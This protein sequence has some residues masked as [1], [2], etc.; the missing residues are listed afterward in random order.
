[1][2]IS[3]IDSPYAATIYVNRISG[4]D[5]SGNGTSGAP[6]KSF[7]KG[8]SMALS[9]D[10]LDLVGTF[11]WT[12]IDETGD[13][14]TSGYTISKNITIQ[15]RGIDET[16]IQAHSS[17]YSADRRVFTLGAFAINFKNLTIRHGYL[18]AASYNAGGAGI[19]MNNG[20]SNAVNFEKCRI[21]KNITTTS[22][23][24]SQW[25]GG[26]AILVYNTSATGGS[27]NFEQCIINDNQ[28]T[29]EQGAAIWAYRGTTG[30]FKMRFSNSTINGNLSPSNKVC[31]MAYYIDI[32]FV[33]TTLT[34]NQGSFII[35]SMYK[36]NLNLTNSTIAYNLVG[37]TGSAVHCG[38]NFDG[39]ITFYIKNTLIAANKV[40]A[41]NTTDIYL[42]SPTIYDN[43][44]NLIE[45][46]SAS[47]FTNNVNGN[48]IGVQASLNLSSTLALNNTNNKIPTLELT[49]GSPA[50]DAGSTGSNGAET[51][52]TTD[53]RIATRTGLP[54]IGSFE[55][56][57]VPMP[58]TLV[59]FTGNCD[60][61]VATLKWQT[62]SEKNSDRFVV[63][64]SIDGTTWL[65]IDQ[66]KAAGFSTELI[67]YEY[68]IHEGNHE[69]MAYY[70][71]NQIDFDGKNEIFG[72]VYINCED[73]IKEM[74]I[75]PNPVKEQLTLKFNSE[76]QEDGLL[77]IIDSF[78]SIVYTQTIITELG[79]NAIFIEQLDLMP[80]IYQLRLNENSSKFVVL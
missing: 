41:S 14:A 62:A 76:S 63:E 50:I 8:Y 43:G 49:S 39:P 16:I 56:D 9:G 74:Y 68:T 34:A 51:V 55:F 46:Q 11:T 33:N 1:M 71:L 79:N 7:H 54:D 25:L 70:R 58:V 27:M 73:K 40:L 13:A 67:N 52:L 60:G 28:C 47:Y 30:T 5:A 23:T 21:E 44:N 22:A 53:A 29:N 38:Y 3:I 36:G 15:G 42:S 72:P 35:G 75:F 37:A 57:G 64:A 26:G 18:P 17:T 12:D 59:Y 2:T 10:I 78:G 65:A 48:K 24:G 61:S 45:T 32:T 20:N 77:E 31:I 66:V 80:G 69:R 6:Y 4:D 19:Y